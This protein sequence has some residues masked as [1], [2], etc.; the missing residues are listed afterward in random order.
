M[1]VYGMSGFEVD[2]QFYTDKAG[3]VHYAYIE[4]NFKKVLTFLNK[5]YK[6]ELIDP[7]YPTNTKPVWLAKMSNGTCG[8]TVDWF[9]NL[10][11]IENMG[12]A[13]GDKG[14]DISMIPPPIGPT[15]IQMTTSQQKAVSGFTAI[16]AK[17]K[18]KAEITR[19][20]DYFYSPEGNRLMNFGVEGP[21]YTMEN[22]K[23]VYTDMMVKNPNGKSVLQMLFTVGHRE[24]AYKQDINYEDQL[25]TDQRSRDARDQYVKYIKPGYPILPY[26]PAERNL[27]NAK[28]TEIQTYKDEMVNKF[29]M[30][31]ESLDK[32]DE[33]VKKINAM[34]IKDVLKVQQNAYKRYMK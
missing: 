16:S 27:M 24:W 30:G 14:I 25:L 13:S 12:K 18:Y 29:I 15:G 28:Y 11:P 5:L 9:T 22:G 19:L 26:T 21:H 3:K 17:S 31:Q 23:P 8:A 7:E 1:E 33:F 2:E 10:T 32:F 20:F 6:E 4:P 34:G